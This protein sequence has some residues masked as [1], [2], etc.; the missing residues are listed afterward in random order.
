MKFGF[1]RRGYSSTGGAEAYLKRL[2]KAVAEAGHSSVLFCS[3]DWPES[4]WP[5]G[6]RVIV[7]GRSPMSFSRALQALAPRRR[8][9]YLF[10]LERIGFCDCF[11]AGDGVHASWLERRAR[12]EPFWKPFFR[13]FQAR[14]RELLEIERKVFSAQGAQTIIANSNLVKDE[15][16]S[17]FDF[18]SDK[19]HVVYNGVPSVQIPPGLRP[20]ARTRFGVEEDALTIAFVGSGWE[21]KGLRFAIEAVRKAKTKKV[22][23]IIA[24]RGNSN[25]YPFSHRLRFVGPQ[26]DM[27]PLLAASDLFLLPTIYDPFS[28]ACLEALAAGLPVLTTRD[29][30]FSEIIRSGVEGEVFESPEAVDAMASAIDAWADPKRRESVRGDLVRL[31]ASYSMEK[32]LENTLRALGLNVGISQPVQ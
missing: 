20:K 13:K 12:Y 4:Q 2:G 26:S 9:D 14:H 29:N 7:A 24:G 10:S 21:R 22:R 25:K 31:G 6:E 28:N 3:S 16:A 1:V 30:G 27:V 15:I 19:V 11:R 18:P 8:C 32:N 23:L 5:H 17:R